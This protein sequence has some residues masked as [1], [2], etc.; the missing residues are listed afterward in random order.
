MSFNIGLN[1]VETEGTATPSIQ[2]APVSN[3][4]FSIVSERGI[5][6][7]V[8]RVTSWG[9]FV[10]RFGA[11]TSDGYG[12]YAIRGFFDNGGSRAFVTRVAN[13]P[14][15][16]TATLNDGSESPVDVLTVTAA[17]RNVE[18]PGEWGNKIK[19]SIQENKGDTS[20]FD[21]TVNYKGNIVEVWDGLTMDSTESRY[22]ET[23][24]NNE[25][26]GSKYIM[27]SVVN[28]E[29]SNPGKTKP[30]NGEDQPVPLEDGDNGSA[31]S[32]LDFKDSIDL[33]ELE[34]VQLLC[35]PETTE[36]IVVT[37]G[38]NRSA[39]LGDRMFLGHIPEGINGFEDIKNYSEDFTADKVYGAL[40]F[41]WIQVSDPL[42]VRKWVP[43]TGHILGVYD[44][45][46]R[47]RGP[48]KAP[49]GNSAGLKG[50]LDVKF[51]ITDTDHTDIV[52]SANV[53]AVR[54]IS[55]QGIVVDSSRTLSTNP[56]WFYVNVRQ[57]FNFVK[58]SLK[59]SLRWVV[60]EPNDETL[61]NKV[62]YNSVVPFLMGL[63]RQGAFGP[64]TP[65]Q[66]FKVKIDGDNNR[67]SDIEQGLF[68]AEIY[69]YPSHPAETV[70]LKV[71]QQEGG[72][73]AS[74]S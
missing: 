9:Q 73:N 13:S 6:G 14:S 19:I 60:Q 43:P 65:D 47:A 17:Y 66:V 52:K 72:A 2:A 41:P 21:L 35:C 24:I 25:L 50:A 46:A 69:F 22:V 64:G 18:D 54:F 26:S 32:D 67:P 7:K 3:A 30:E 39:A 36:E 10:E 63:W 11:Y 74:E 48:W 8:I 62:K 56:L 40:Y 16:A 5:P 4:G 61:W 38:L 31:P 57:L 28:N 44:R 58:S 71:G 33:F 20:L 23:L 15:A 49:A 1:I 68:T 37:H 53:N 55:G 12:A 70:V 51:H 59:N 29:T 42:G 27:A 34:D 45:I